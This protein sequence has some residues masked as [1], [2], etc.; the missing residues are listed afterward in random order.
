MVD[1]G[2][3]VLVMSWASYAYVVTLMAFD[4]SVYQFV[5]PVVRE[6]GGRAVYWTILRIS[7]IWAMILL[8]LSFA[9]ASAIDEH[10]IRWI[11]IFCSLYVAGRA[12][13]V[14][15]LTPYRCEERTA[16][17]FC[18]TALIDFIELCIITAVLFVA[19]DL[20]SILAWLA[21]YYWLAGAFL[22]LWQ[23]RRYPPQPSEPEIV[24]PSILFGA[25]MTISQLISTGF[26]VL[27]K[28]IVTFFAGLSAVAVYA[29]PIALAMALMP[30]NTSGGITLPTLLVSKEAR[31]SVEVKCKIVRNAIKQWSLLAIPAAVGV[32]LVA[33]PALEIIANHHIAEYG[34]PIA[35]LA[36]PAVVIDGLGRFAFSV[37]RAENDVR[38]IT[39]LKIVHFVG[40]LVISIVACLVFP[41]SVCYN[42]VI[43]LLAANVSYA[44]CSFLRMRRF[45]PDAFSLRSISSPLS[46]SAAIM[47]IGA[48]TPR[49]ETFPW[50]LAF[51]CLCVAVYA[52]IIVRME[53]IGLREL[54]MLLGRA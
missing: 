48:I 49:I 25:S 39:I 22:F 8:G 30:L 41:E 46:G 19:R 40:Y 18:S 44:T 27:D 31:A 21:I 33:R 13:C 2:R 7:A 14:M 36:A 20:L 42:I 52:G 10:N 34:A 12:V 16:L 17:F 43:V 51:I 9:S 35:W 26:Y 54:R 53:R 37:L 24:K 32:A 11:V 5:T 23:R 6:T 1:Y 38:W 47:L 29:P 4:I 45:V 15:F 3:W 28:S 50:L